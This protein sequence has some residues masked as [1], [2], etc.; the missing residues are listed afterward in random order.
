MKTYLRVIWGMIV[1]STFFMFN[2][3]T[4]KI[5]FI[6]AI[7]SF[8]ASVMF[9][10]IQKTEAR[11]SYETVDMAYEIYNLVSLDGSKDVNGRHTQGFFVGAGF[12][13]EDLYYHFFYETPQGIKYDKRQA[14]DMYPYIYI[15]E[16]DGPPQYVRYG[17]FYSDEREKYYTPEMIKSTRDVLYIPKGTINRNYKVN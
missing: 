7:L 9:K 15:I 3:D 8:P 10:S 16:R 1:D 14:D 12:V 4:L 13:S 6:V 17:K 11:K 2:K 5:L